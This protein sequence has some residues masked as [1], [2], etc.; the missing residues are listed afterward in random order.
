MQIVI[1]ISEDDYNFIKEEEFSNYA[2]TTRLYTA[3][4]NGIPL[5]ESKGFETDKE[6]KV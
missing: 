3:V 2:I 1:D 4:Y 6:S 5:P